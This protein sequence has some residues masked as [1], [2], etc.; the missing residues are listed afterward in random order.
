MQITHKVSPGQ[1]GAQ[2]LLDH[3]SSKL[4]CARY[5]YDKQKQKRCKT[6]SGS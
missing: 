1:R 2:S 3:S 6:V 5:R 4:A